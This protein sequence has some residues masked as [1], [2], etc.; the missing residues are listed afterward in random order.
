MEKKSNGLGIASMVLG[1]IA[2]LLSCCYGGFLGIIG[3]ILGIIVVTK[4][5]VKKGTA[6][7]GIITSGIALLLTLILLIAGSGSLMDY[8]EQSN[9]TS[10]INV[11]TDTSDALSNSVTEE[12]EAND[13]E[14]T[15]DAY[16]YNLEVKVTETNMYTI[17]SVYGNSE[18][19]FSEMLS[20]ILDAA[21]SYHIEEDDATITDEFNSLIGTEGGT[22]NT[23]NDGGI[24]TSA[25]NDVEDTYRT[26][27]YIYK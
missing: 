24:I 25:P 23:W 4:Q 12:T 18:D 22:G 15:F 11:S 3:L 2:L 21:H 19:D 8:M 13:T 7:A 17:V 27:L 26:D 9:D 6:I 20:I 16:S 10:Q 5:D 1:I 14:T